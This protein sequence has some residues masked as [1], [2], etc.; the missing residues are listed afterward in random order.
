MEMDIERER[1][2]SDKNQAEVEKLKAET[3]KVAIEVAEAKERLEAK[4]VDRVIKVN[5]EVRKIFSDGQTPESI[6]LLEFSNLLNAFPELAE[7]LDK[8]EALATKLKIQHGTEITIVPSQKQ[9]E[10]PVDDPV[11]NSPGEQTKE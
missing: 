2:G 5:E 3:Q 4:N 9:I 1:D 6:K 7:Q 10:E 8:I 11:E